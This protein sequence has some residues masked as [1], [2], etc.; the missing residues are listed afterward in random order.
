MTQRTLIIMKPDAM[1]RGIWPEIFGIFLKAGFVQLAS[2]QVKPP[3]AQWLRHYR[4]LDPNLQK[5]VIAFMMQTPVIVAV[6]E[7]DNAVANIHDRVGS[8][9]PSEAEIGTIRHTFGHAS[10]GPMKSNFVHSSANGVEA[11][12]EI[13]LWFRK[14]EI[15]SYRPTYAEDAY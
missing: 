15:H 1:K 8:T 4:D 2:K 10:R 13:G 12:R 6:L 3:R 9:F 11:K 14:N 7:G 5:E